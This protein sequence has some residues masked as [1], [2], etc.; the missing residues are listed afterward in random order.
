LYSFVFY[1]GS[2]Q[3]ILLYNNIRKKSPVFKKEKEKIQIILQEE[4]SKM[5]EEKRRGG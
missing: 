1:G 5:K 2:T 3:C 4:R